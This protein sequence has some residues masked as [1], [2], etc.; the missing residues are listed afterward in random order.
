MEAFTMPVVYSTDRR[1]IGKIK[2]HRSGSIA[3]F[4]D[5]RYRLGFV[6]ENMAVTAIMD[7]AQPALKVEG[8]LAL[9]EALIEEGE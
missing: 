6:N 9:V 4:D 3:A 7:C 1:Q 5:K 8:Y 2:P